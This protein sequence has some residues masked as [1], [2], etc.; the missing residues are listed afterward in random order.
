MNNLSILDAS[1]ILAF[2]QREKGHELVE[3]AL[4]GGQCWVST[5]NICEVLGKLCDHGVPIKEA[6]LAV[7]E[8]GLK[9]LEFDWDH[10]RTAADLRAR[11]RKI[12]ASLGDRACL[13]LAHY[14]RMTGI[15]IVVYTAEQAWARIDW[16]FEIVLIRASRH[17][18]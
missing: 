15:P 17:K 11:T 14:C 8:L 2:L 5:V 1:A 10:T 6:E 18:A 13:A 7:N 4:D 16:P 9:V 12:G 3:A